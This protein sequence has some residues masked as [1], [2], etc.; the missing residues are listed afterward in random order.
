MLLP[1]PVSSSSI[2]DR[3]GGRHSSL[4]ITS[5]IQLLFTTPYS[6]SCSP[7]SFRLH[8][9][10]TIRPCSCS[11]RSLSRCS[12]IFHRCLRLYISTSAIS[13]GCLAR[14]ST[15]AREIKQRS[16]VSCCL[17]LQ[18][19]RISGIFRPRVVILK[20]ERFRHA[21]MKHEVPELR[22]D[23]SE[24]CIWFLRRNFFCKHIIIER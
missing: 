3:S 22:Q 7:L 6:V 2:P 4:W 23:E 19:P 9:A 1:L 15:T 14:G 10:R 11:D 24:P 13:C 8:S 16:I 18:R 20:S 12:H 5:A 21:Q 17:F